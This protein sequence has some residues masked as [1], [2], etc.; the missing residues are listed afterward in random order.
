MIKFGA[1]WVLTF[2]WN[3]STSEDL[4]QREFK[5]KII[6]M[7]RLQCFLSFG[8][9][10]IC[11]SSSVALTPPVRSQRYPRGMPGLRPSMREKVR[12]GNSHSD[13]VKDAVEVAE[14]EKMVYFVENP[15]S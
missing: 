11:S 10:L 2:E 14:E 6:K 12:D 13:F 3:R 8:A 9:A 5:E 15:D 1:P 4:L 7:M